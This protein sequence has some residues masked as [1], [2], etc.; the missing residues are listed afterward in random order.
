VSSFNFLMWLAFPLSA[1]SMLFVLRRW[2]SWYPAAFVGGLIYGFSPYVIGQGRLHLQLV[3]VPVPPLIALA[4]YELFVKR[5]GHVLAWGAVL[6]ILVSAQF[7]ISTE[8]LASTFIVVVIGLV[9]LGVSRPGDSLLSIRTALPGVGVAAGVVVVVLAY[10]AWMLVFGPQRYVVPESVA[11]V[12]AGR[13]G[14]L[15]PITPT[16]SMWFA[17]RGLSALG[18]ATPGFNDA[19]ENGSYLGIPLILLATYLAVRFRRCRWLLF[20]AVM[21]LASFLLTLGPHLD[22]GGERTSIALPFALIERIPLVGLINPI[23]MSL[24]VAMFV[25]MM[26]AVGLNEFW[27]A[28]TRRGAQAQSGGHGMRAPLRPAPGEAL[29]VGLL[30]A[31]SALSLIPS[32][33]VRT[34]AIGVP[35]YF[36]SSA[37]DRIRPGSTVL[38]YPYPTPGA[39]QGMLWQALTGM[40]FDLLGSYALNPDPHGLV[41]QF[42][43]QLR[44]ADLQRLFYGE[45]KVTPALGPP[46]PLSSHRA[47]L[48]ADIRT[49]LREHHVDTVLVAPR[50]PQAPVITR[51]MSMALGS[52]PQRSGQIDAWYDV[53]RSAPLATGTAVGSGSSN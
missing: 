48:V 36:T 40:R 3:F 8:I 17:P 52:P 31:A 38:M 27:S 51:I 24:F 41:S 7:L 26:V 43:E 14:L 19:V 37:V 4:V 16:S 5:K 29:L 25:S 18:R 15:G 50:Q 45:E 9:V 11:N 10:P 39:A 21:A 20:M 2:T 53:P 32:W 23:R 46:F 22:L 1:S 13:S 28:W 35:P 49:F 12:F 47:A 33:P 44:P 6:G 42:P 30:L 34:V